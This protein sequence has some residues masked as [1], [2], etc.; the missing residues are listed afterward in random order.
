MT[1]RINMMS[2]VALL[3]FLLTTSVTV[4]GQ[5]NPSN[6]NLIPNVAPPTP[7][8][9]KLGQ[10]G[11]Y[12]VNY[13]TG[14]V[15]IDIPLYEIK[16]GDLTVPISLRYHTSGIKVTEKAS[17]VGLGWSL[18]PGGTVS[19]TVM[20]LADELNGGYLNSTTIRNPINTYYLT[21]LMYLDDVVRGRKDTEINHS[22]LSTRKITSVRT[23]FLYQR[24]VPN[25]NI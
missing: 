19:R 22:H 4:I 3:T 2:I 6:V 23:P 18:E 13:F 17:W 11:Q 1:S 15:N 8:V 24:S 5:T 12:P 9:A 10:F 7:D 16:A 25:L 21:D 14:L 20:G